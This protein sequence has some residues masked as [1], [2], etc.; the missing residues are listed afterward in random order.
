[1]RFIETPI[2]GTWI[3][4]LEKLEDDRGFFGRSFC[5]NEFRERGLRNTIAQSNVSFNRKRGTIRG[6]H[7][8][9]PPYGEAKLVRCTQ[10]AIW[11]VVVDLRPNSHTFK[12]WYGVELSAEN[13]RSLYIPEDMAHGFQTLTD[14]AEVLYLMSE[15][16][17]SSSA[18]GVRWNDPL[19][20]I[21][22]PIPHPILSE[23]DRA[24]PDF[25]K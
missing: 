16:Y 11:D 24:F 5:Q 7:Y 25:I 8:Q 18:M 1:M 17:H 3:V 6:M 20:D 22:W 15:F 10:G 9:A 4:D 14:D 12:R 19:F 13:R 23:R 2:N 21:H